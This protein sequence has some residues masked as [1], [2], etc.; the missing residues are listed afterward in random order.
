MS[1]KAINS[2]GTRP[3]TKGRSGISGFNAPKGATVANFY[4][5]ETFLGSTGVFQLKP[6]LQ[7]SSDLAKVGTWRSD[8]SFFGNLIPEMSPFRITVKYHNSA[9]K[10]LGISHSDL[11]FYTRTPIPTPWV[12]PRGNTPLPTPKP[13]APIAPVVPAPKPPTPV[14]PVAPVAPAPKP[15]TPIAPVAPVTPVVPAFKTITMSDSAL[16][17]N[18]KWGEAKNLPLFA[19]GISFRDARQ[20][21]VGTCQMIASL[22]TYAYSRP[23]VI[24]RNISS[25]GFSSTVKILPTYG[26]NLLI[27]VSNS[28]SNTYARNTTDNWVAI[29]EKANLAAAINGSY[30]ISGGPKRS[31]YMIL[32]FGGSVHYTMDNTNPLNSTVRA[33][34]EKVAQGY[35]GVLGYNAHA[36][37]A[38][39]HDVNTGKWYLYNPYG[40]STDFIPEAAMNS[41]FQFT[42]RSETYT[43]TLSDN[44]KLTTTSGVDKITGTSGNDVIN[45]LAGDDYINGNGGIDWLTGGAGYDTFDLRSYAKNGI[46]DYAVVQDW[47]SVKDIAILDRNQSYTLGNVSTFDNMISRSLSTTSGDLIAHF[48]GIETDLQALSLNSTSFK[49]M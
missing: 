23:D 40:A 49:F 31:G 16:D 32:D 14:A 34:G 17:A 24:E 29:Y 47:W 18:N 9:N 19:N 37:A 22:A 10:V 28:L 35:S 26:E 46:N 20:G 41:G 39:D 30:S 21:A 27:K 1:I 33:A 44:S 6:G 4:I 15:P 12:T 42:G 36:Y 2:T 38:L 7:S 3:I 8:L 5:G 25:D 11:I 43:Q 13:P 45:A 48:Q